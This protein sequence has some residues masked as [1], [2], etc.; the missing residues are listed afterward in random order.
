MVTEATTPSQAQFSPLPAPSFPPLPCEG[1]PSANGGGMLASHLCS[2]EAQCRLV[3]PGLHDHALHHG[4]P[5]FSIRG[6]HCIFYT[7]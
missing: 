1:L 5:D 3:L 6:S 4:S 7:F 2:V